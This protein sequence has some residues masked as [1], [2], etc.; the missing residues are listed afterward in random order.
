MALLV[1]PC[2]CQLLSEVL[3]TWNLTSVAGNRCVRSLAGNT[4]VN[5]RQRRALWMLAWLNGG[6]SGRV[7][8]KMGKK[9]ERTLASPSFVV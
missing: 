3:R 5:R 1:Q 9:C 7:L 6:L 2:P 8:S 4:A